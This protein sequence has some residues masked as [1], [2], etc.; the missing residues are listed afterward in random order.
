M[1]D[2]ET[3][4]V[5]LQNI[6]ERV[7]DKEE[8]ELKLEDITKAVTDAI[9]PLD[10]RLQKLEKSNEEVPP[11]A[12]GEQDNELLKSVKADSSTSCRTY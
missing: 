10:E 5:A 6:I 2:I 3:A 12:E 8:D 11:A 7:S 9:A 4:Q 1:A